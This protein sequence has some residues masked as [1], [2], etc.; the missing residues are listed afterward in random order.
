[1]EYEAPYYMHWHLDN[2]ETKMVSLNWNGNMGDKEEEERVSTICPSNFPQRE[3]FTFLHD[4][5]NTKTHAEIHQGH[6]EN[7]TVKKHG[8]NSASTMDKMDR[9]YTQRERA[10]TTKIHSRSP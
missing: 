6:K 10:R 9:N 3:Q 7:G 2:P 1:M 4:N 8:K 5:C